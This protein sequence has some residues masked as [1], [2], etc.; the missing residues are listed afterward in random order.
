MLLQIGINNANKTCK[1]LLDSGADVNIMAEH[2][3][4]A[5]VRQPLTSTS[6][7]L[8]S[9]A[10]QEVNCQGM[11][12]VS[13]FVDGCKEACQF[14][15][16]G[17]EESAHDIILGRAWM[18]RHRCQFDWEERNI[19][20]VIGTKQITLP[21]ATKAT[22]MPT[23]PKAD[24]VATSLPKERQLKHKGVP[25]N[26]S[27]RMEWLPKQL[28][29]EQHFYEGN[30][31]IW[32]PKCKTASVSISQFAQS[33]KQVIK[34]KTRQRWLPKAWLQA[35]N[36]YQGNNHIWVPKA[37]QR[38]DRPKQP[39][40]PESISQQHQ[41]LSPP[42]SE[43]GQNDTDTTKQLQ[44]GKGKQIS[45]EPYSQ[46]ELQGIHQNIIN[47]P[48]TSLFPWSTKLQQTDS[49]LNIRQRA[50]LLQCKLF[51]KSSLPQACQ[52]AVC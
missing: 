22:I 34:T 6:A 29:R 15:V 19:H 1:A 48:S 45:N 30:N 13:V 46:A 23:I 16:T 40:K 38:H 10:N 27:I 17:S 51:G 32:V 36:F 8:N 42:K 2:I 41:P 28:L 31:Y 52:V 37:P 11:V 26:A 44:K 35:Q 25:H 47:L 18:H 33:S 5:F 43:K 50:Q 12:T 9:I 4:N 24:W 21:E 14:Y 39:L 20:L 49:T 7:Q 3:Y